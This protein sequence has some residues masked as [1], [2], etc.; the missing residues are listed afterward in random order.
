MLMITVRLSALHPHHINARRPDHHAVSPTGSGDV[1]LACVLTALH[2]RGATL[3]QAVAFALPFAAANASH[4]GV[5]EF[6]DPR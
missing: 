3:D 2:A 4:P 1:L 6:P 5:A